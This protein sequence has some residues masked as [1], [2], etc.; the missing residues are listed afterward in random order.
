MRLRS[1]HITFLQR[2]AWLALLVCFAAIFPRLGYAEGGKYMSDPGFRILVLQIFRIN[3]AMESAAQNPMDQWRRQNVAH[4]MGLLPAAIVSLAG[5]FQQGNLTDSDL[6]PVEQML[7]GFLNQNV[8]EMYTKFMQHPDRKLIPKVGNNFPMPVGAGN[9][10]DSQSLMFDDATG[11]NSGTASSPLD[12]QLASPLAGSSPANKTKD[13]QSLVFDD[14]A[15]KSDDSTANGSQDST[16]SSSGKSSASQLD[17]DLASIESSLVSSNGGLTGGPGP[18]S[19]SGNSTSNSAVQPPPKNEDSLEDSQKLAEDATSKKMG[20]RNQKA[21]RKHYRIKPNPSYW[22]VVP[23]FRLSEVLLTPN[24]HA[25]G[26]EAA[27]ILFGVAAMIAAAAPV[28]ASMQQA[29]ADK[30]IAAINAN[31]QKAMT[32][33]T[34]QTTLALSQRQAQISQNQSQTAKDMAASNQQFSQQKL[35]MQ[36][37]SLKQARQDQLQFDQKKQAFDQQIDQQRIQLAQQQAQQTIAL[38]DLQFKTQLT[39]LGLSNGLSKTLGNASVLSTNRASVPQG[40]PVGSTGIGQSALARANS[41]SMASNASTAGPQLG[42]TI[43]SRL[44]SGSNA[45]INSANIA[46][47]VLADRLLAS[48]VEGANQT[49]VG[50]KN[51]G[52]KRAIRSAMAPLGDE[53]EAE[54]VPMDR[55]PLLRTAMARN[56]LVPGSTTKVHLKGTKSRGTMFNQFMQTAA[57]AVPNQENYSS[58]RGERSAESPKL[59]DSPASGTHQSVSAYNAPGQVGAEVSLRKSGRTRAI[60]YTE[61]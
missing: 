55:S 37:D 19:G 34:S 16:S 7:G 41:S 60:A 48:G 56:A 28:M 14:G 38:N 44:S 1:A 46:R 24:A 57:R 42:N 43:G 40:A 21:K 20:K 36:L 6:A 45:A 4:E 10:R 35:T 11:K 12:G 3:Q 5:S 9:K 22:S 52:G 30:Q 27:A 13:S 49:A 17:R 61:D 53:S 32:D 59:A 50:S 2:R 39:A 58:F 25:E 8:G 31:A 51:A 33:Q 15:K 47:G 54:A 23:L 26:Q 29:N 18:S